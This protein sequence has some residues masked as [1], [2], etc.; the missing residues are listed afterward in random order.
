MSELFYVFGGL[1]TLM[2]IVVAFAGMRSDNFPSSG[3]MRGGLAVMGVLVVGACA[4]AIILSREEHEVREKEIFEYREELAAEESA[5]EAEDGSSTEE[6][7][8]TDEPVD[9]D[10]AEEDALALTS[11]EEGDLVF[12]PET[13]EA[14]AGEIT[15]D[16]T[17]PSE[18]PHNVAIEDG[19]ET[20]AQGATVTGGESGPAT[21]DLEA[22]E[23]VYYCSVPSHREAGMVG[24]LT[25]E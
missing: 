9:T 21:A 24:T 1:L 13:L 25:V 11:P 10:E 18:V 4:F 20:V 17:N 3:L 8:E 22:G 5:A 7:S 15:I 6:D 2:A 12:E 16:Y 14:E 19:S 23:Y